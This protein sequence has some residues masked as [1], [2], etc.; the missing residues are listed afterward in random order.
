[1]KTGKP[2]FEEVWNRIKSLEGAKFKT[3]T[4]LPFTF[5]L[6]GNTFKPS[7]TDYNI[8]KSDFKKAFDRV[9]F[10]DGPSVVNKIV[11]GPSYIWAVLHDKRIRRSDW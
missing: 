7:R 4:G 10:D 5:K 11:R 9:P 6:F 2:P 3:K 8:A 1:M